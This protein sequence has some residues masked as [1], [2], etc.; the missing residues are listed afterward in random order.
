MYLKS[1]N[2]SMAQRKVVSPGENVAA[3]NGLR[4]LSLLTDTKP[5]MNWQKWIDRF[6]VDF[7]AKYS[8]S[9]NKLTRKGAGNKERKIKTIVE[10][11]GRAY[12]VDCCLFQSRRNAARILSWKNIQQFRFQLSKLQK[13]SNIVRTAVRIRN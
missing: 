12:Q 5:K 9:L 10:Q 11:L 6:Q 3:S 1:E 13:Y 4:M 2:A 7:S 8:M